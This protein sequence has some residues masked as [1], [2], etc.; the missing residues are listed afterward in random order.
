MP[1]ASSKFLFTSLRRKLLI[2]FFMGVKMKFL[3]KT[4]RELSLA[5]LLQLNG[6]Y[7]GSSGGGGSRSPSGRSGSSSY[8]GSSSGGKSSKYGAQAKRS[9]QNTS[10]AY[11]A[12]SGS[13]GYLN[14]ERITVVDGRAYSSLTGFLGGGSDVSKQAENQSYDAAEA[15]RKA[16]EAARKAQGAIDKKD[17]YCSKKNYIDL[18]YGDAVDNLHALA[19][20]GELNSNF[21]RNDDKYIAHQIVKKINSD[22]RDGNINY[23][24]GM[25]CDDYAQSVLAEVGIGYSKYFAGEADK[26]NC[27]EH[28]ANLKKDGKYDSSV[29]E[30]GSVYVCFMG[31][32]TVDEHC[33]LLIASENGGF[34][35]ADNSSGNWG[36]NG[37]VNVDYATS[38]A[39]V[40]RAYRKNYSK[41]YYQKV[42]KL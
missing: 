6:G 41:F 36:K 17:P 37:G 16:E 33:A 29:V 22:L 20:S 14:K 19:D 11:S 32:G 21:L 23:E 3:L 35:M 18:G 38:L 39:G 25:M 8:S 9:A 2:D 1:K 30:K 28:I 7:G 4:S 24:K 13:L 5:E 26:K 15:A 42:T 40:E 27:A 34:Y 31:G 12:T 10:R